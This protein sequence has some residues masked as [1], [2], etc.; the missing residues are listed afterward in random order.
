MS[1]FE[2]KKVTCP[3]CSKQQNVKVYTSVNVTLKPELKEDLLSRNIFLRKCKYCESSFELKHPLL[4]NNMEYR[5]LLYYIPGIDNSKIIDTSLEEE[6]KTLQPIKCRIVPD[7]DTLKEKISIFESG[8][9]DMAIEITKLAVLGGVKD[10]INGNVKRVMFSFCHREKNTIGFEFETDNEP[11]CQSTRLEIYQ[12]AKYVVRKTAG[13]DKEMKGFL[14]IDSLWAEDML[15]RFKLR[16]EKR[17]QYL[18]Q[19]KKSDS[20]EPVKFLLDIKKSNTT[21]EE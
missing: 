19:S 15:S 7:F 16:Q 13:L 6:Y 9:D 12:K 21:D 10:K 14:K 2:V 4:Y 5:F 1:D 3:L 18:K 17:E 20:C 8:L 11:Y